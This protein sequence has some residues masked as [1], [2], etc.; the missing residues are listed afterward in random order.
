MRQ[1]APALSRIIDA[2]CSLILS[3]SGSSDSAGDSV[4]MPLERELGIHTRA[5]PGGCRWHVQDTVQR[6]W[7]ALALML[8]IEP[9]IHPAGAEV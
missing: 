6:A 9:K 3:G 8:K 7:V 5:I 2:T 1:S 4:R